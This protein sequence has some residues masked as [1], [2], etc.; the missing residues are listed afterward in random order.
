MGK[1]RGNKP[2]LSL[3]THN[4]VILQA[5]R[6]Q[7]SVAAA[8]ASELTPGHPDLHEEAGDE[9]ESRCIELNTVTDATQDHLGKLDQTHEQDQRQQRTPGISRRAL[10]MCSTMWIAQQRVCGS[11]LDTV[12]PTRKL[13]GIMSF[14]LLDAL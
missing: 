4:I 1:S 3:C 9:C 11:C 12:V 13:Q 8:L 2:F 7:A 10:G 6:E 5:K 14:D